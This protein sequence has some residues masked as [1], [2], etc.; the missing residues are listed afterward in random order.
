MGMLARHRGHPF[1]SILVDKAYVGPVV[2]TPHVYRVA[3]FKGRITPNQ[4]NYNT[5]HG[6]ARVHIERVFGR[7]KMMFPNVCG[8]YRIGH[9]H[10]DEDIMICMFLVNISLRRSAL[11]QIDYEYFVKL[12]ELNRQKEQERHD[13]N[14]VKAK[15]DR[16]AKRRRLGLL[17][18]QAENVGAPVDQ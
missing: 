2:D 9:D 18:E 13:I 15:N 16:T 8:R 1:W 12:L 3:P 10:F 17:P 11:N 7:A 4:A 5:E 6:S 14:A